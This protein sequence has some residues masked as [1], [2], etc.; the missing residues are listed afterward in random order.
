MAYYFYKCSDFVSS[1]CIP[2]NEHCG[3]ISA[4]EFRIIETIFIN[5][6][7]CWC[8][9]SFLWTFFVTGLIKKDESPL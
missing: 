3:D 6:L 4:L 8:F 9:Y 7:Y 5:E 1:P 2:G